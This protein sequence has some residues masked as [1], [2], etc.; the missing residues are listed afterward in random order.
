MAPPLFDTLQYFEK[1]R[2]AHVPEEQAKAWVSA[3]ADAL[4]EAF[5]IPPTATAGAADIT[6]VKVA[7]PG[8]DAKPESH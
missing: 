6:S 3:L 7:A 5:G 8:S 1:L 4:A 2:A